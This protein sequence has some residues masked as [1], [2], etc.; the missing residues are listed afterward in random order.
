[1]SKNQEITI[2]VDGFKVAGEITFR[3]EG[4]IAVKILSPYHDLSSSLHIPYFSRPYHSFLTD[5]GDSTA[6][7]L[8]KY[9]YELGHYLEENVNY[10]KMQLC[11]HFHDEDYSSMECQERFFGS[12]FPFVVPMGTRSD[13]LRRLLR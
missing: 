3:S 13:V 5:Y 7:N 2:E 9:L 10:V 4:D 1:M 8:L 11:L 12:T 6:Q